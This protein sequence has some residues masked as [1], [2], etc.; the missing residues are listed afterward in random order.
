MSTL[1][2]DTS[3]P[4][5][6]SKNTIKET[7]TPKISFRINPGNNMD[8]YSQE[9]SN[10]NVNNVFDI[11]RLGLTNDFEAGRSLTLGLDY[12]FDLIENDQIQ[13][14]KSKDKYLEFK[15]ATVL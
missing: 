14:D 1:K 7:L 12:K 6:K 11:N 3:F 15:L 4:L 9:I 10:I 5:I 8:N 13:L 2:I